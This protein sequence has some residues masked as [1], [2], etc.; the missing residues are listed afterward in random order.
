MMLKKSI[1]LLL[2]IVMTF[3][4]AVT[5][6]ATEV[7]DTQA[8]SNLTLAKK[9]QIQEGVST[10]TKDTIKQLSFDELQYASTVAET[11]EVATVIFDAL[12]EKYASGTVNAAAKASLISNYVQFV[13]ATKSGKNVTVK[14]RIKAK[15]PNGASIYLMYE[16]PSQTRTNGASASLSGKK[17]GEY[18]QKFT[19]PTLMCQSRISSHM[20]ARDYKE[21]KVH[22]TYNYKSK[23]YT[24]YHTVTKVEAL[25][26]LAVKT[27]APAVVCFLIPKARVAKVVRKAIDVGGLVVSATVAMSVSIGPPD[28]EAGQY[29]KTQTWY[30]NNRIYVKLKVWHSKAAFDHG[31][32]PIYDSKAS[33][34]A[35]LPTF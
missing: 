7:D 22:E 18:T 33:V 2:A 34:A 12:V 9:A 17:I 5:A 6:F 10:Y 1:S 19:V 11:D 35:K 13:K 25:G 14:Y 8:G 23:V 28:K 30:A 27:A 16:F 26:E 15:I 32:L 24:D 3:S 29:Y 4:L 20:T 31:D 21:T